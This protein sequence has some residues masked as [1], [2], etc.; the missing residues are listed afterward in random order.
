[1]VKII[2][3]FILLFI[4][5]MIY[6]FIVGGDKMETFCNSIKTGDSKVNLF[7]RAKELGYKIRI[8]EKN[9][10]EIIM[11]IDEEAM[12]RYICD[13]SISEDKVIESSYSFNS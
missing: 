12:G 1:M 7:E 11:V 2:G 9:E 6:P 5:Y 13:V 4:I 10:K 3:I 8:F